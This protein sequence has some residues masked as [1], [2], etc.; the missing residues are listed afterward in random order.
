M[1]QDLYTFRAIEPPIVV[2]PAAHHGIDEP[3]QILQALIVRVEAIRQSR[4]VARTALAALVLIAGRK[5]TKNFPQRFFARRGW[6]VYPRKS[7]L[8]ESDF[9]GRSASLQ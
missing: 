5:L 6:K 3:G 9:L 4:M 2:H 8:T 7:N 1:T